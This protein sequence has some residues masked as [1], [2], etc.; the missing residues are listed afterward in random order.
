MLSSR[1]GHKEIPRI[2]GD[3]GLMIDGS[4]L[5]WLMNQNDLKG[6]LQGFKFKIIHRRGVDHNVADGLSQSVEEKEIC[7]ILVIKPD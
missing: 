7:E 4:P 6:R 3:A 2:L 1:N 5:I